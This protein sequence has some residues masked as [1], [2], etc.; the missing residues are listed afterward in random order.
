MMRPSQQARGVK[1]QH[2]N[3]A[4]NGTDKKNATMFSYATITDILVLI[5]SS[6][7]AICAGALNPLLTVIYGHLVDALNGFAKNTV[8]SSGLSSDISKFTL[9]YVYL[10]IA[11]FFFVYTTTVG[12]YYSGG[13][14]A[15]HLR[16]EYLKSILRQN[17]AFFDVLGTGEVSTVIMSDMGVIQEGISSKIALTLTAMA[18]FGSACIISFVMYWKTALILSP[19]Y[20]L[21]AIAGA[22]AGRYAVRY[23]KISRKFRDLGANIAEE[24]IT[25]IRQV[26]SLGMKSYLIDKYDA[27]L[28]KSEIAGVKS[29]MAVAI[30]IG[31]SNAMPCLVYA[32]SFW[33]GSI[34]LVK[35]EM[36]VSAIATTTLSIAIGAFAIVRVT[37][38]IESLIHC[39]TSADSVLQAIARISPQDPFDE[40]GRQLE[41][42]AGD[43]YFQDVSLTYPSREEVVVLDNVRFKAQS[44]KTTAII[45]E[46]GSGKSSI[47]SLL[48]RFYEPTSG[49]ILIDGHDVQSFN[50]RWLRSQISLV[51]QDPVLF[52]TTIFENIRYGLVNSNLQPGVEEIEELV[53]SAAKKANVHDFIKSLPKGYETLVGEKGLQMSGG[54]RQRISIARALISNPKIL[55]LDEATSALDAASEAAVQQALDAA[56]IGRTTI[57]IAHRLS[58][59]RNADK[60][61][62]MSKGRVI[63]EG[64]HESLTEMGG[65]YANFCQK[66]GLDFHGAGEETFEDT[67]K[68]SVHNAATTANSKE[69]DNGSHIS[70]SVC[71]TQDQDATQ[72]SG[73]PLWQALKFIARLNRP[74]LKHMI[75]GLFF[76]VLAGLGIPIQ[77]IFFAKLLAVLAYPPSRFGDLRHS[78][79]IWSGLYVLMAGLALI[80]WVGEG[81]SFSLSTEKL[82]RRAKYHAFKSILQQDISF[83]DEEQH[84]SGNLTTLI[85]SSTEDLTAL[86]GALIGSTLTFLST[87]VAGVVLSLVIGWKLALVCTATI[88][89]VALT[90][91]IRLQI[92]AVFDHQI[93]KSGKESATY[94]SEAV[95]SIRTVAS[96]GLENHI[97]LSYDVILAKQ[98]TES[99]RAIFGASALY[100]LSQSATFLCSALAFWY[101][102]SLVIKREYSLFQF[103]ICLVALISGAQIAGSIFSYA[104][105]ASKA[106]HASKEL[107]TLF[108][109]Q[110]VIGNPASKGSPV[111]K[112]QCNGDIELHNVSFRYPTR[113]N[114]LILNNFSLKVRPGQYIALVGHSGSGKSTILSLLERFYDPESGVIRVD[115]EDITEL[116]LNDYRSMVSLV[117]QETI[118]YSG[119]IRENL[120]VGLKITPPDEEIVRVCRLANIYDFIISLPE[121]FR[122]SVG[123]RGSMLSGG[124]RQRFS[125]A[126]ALLRNPKVLL[127]DEATSALDAESEKVVQA[128]LDAAAKDRT[129]I[130]V[131]HRL[132]TIKHADLIY[133]LDQGRIVEV[134]THPQLIAA[135]G[136]YFGL[137]N[138]QKLL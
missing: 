80:F 29:R 3:R 111:N 107:R 42:L 69:K 93:R 109:R 61:V 126:R 41:N 117:S 26:S 55:L 112:E 90:G 119:T 13:R 123:A 49:A 94:A 76:S 6:V 70:E 82:C 95:S 134:G 131:A 100:A 44:T 120:I 127:L 18:T 14:I 137:V 56:A 54:Q 2:Q 43:I 118:L 22:T 113:P 36:T 17:I 86:S 40:G 1:E 122:T 71:E 136:I 89:L 138:L 98:A 124:Q 16:Y 7:C 72:N 60:I 62:V 30:F 27:C 104:P 39:S 84:A 63:E 50:L 88:P 28:E 129:T 108:D 87:V 25:S 35:G 115:G 135:G 73:L 65:V 67:N 15:R 116:D 32:L 105:D 103:Y 110:P 52:N 9:Y 101:G 83:F 24:A 47:I 8:S 12:F 85:Y 33:A 23:N 64:N 91:W 78:V 20:F 130:A 106:M 114:Q 21:M 5:L 11:V 97:L 58:T 46:S 128:A 53:F 99:Q 121:G 57:V 10:A 79:D 132:S 4:S 102:G 96:L 34:F 45:G 77:S 38:C 37:P 92:L 81:Y 31:V 75:T 125:I 66:Q 74:E 68:E 51:A 48:E 133:V 19:S 59:I